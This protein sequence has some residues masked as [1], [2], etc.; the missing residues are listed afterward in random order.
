MQ[1]HVKKSAWAACL[2]II[3]LI[4]GVIYLY[5]GSYLLAIVALLSAILCIWH[6]IGSLTPYKDEKFVLKV[7]GENGGKLEVA[8]FE[9]RLE[10]VAEPYGIYDGERIEDLQDATQRL[11]IKGRI[12]VRNGYYILTG[13][14]HDN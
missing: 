13:R 8:E 10:Q 9:T 7:L 2:T 3:T 6:F 12:S 11:V 14:K 4:C 1:S 5:V